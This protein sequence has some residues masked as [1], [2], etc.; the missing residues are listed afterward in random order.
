MPTILALDTAS[1]VCSIAL[2]SADGY[3]REQTQTVAREHTQRILPMINEMLAEADIRLQQVDAIAFSCGPGSFTGL[4]ICLSIAQGLAYGADLPLVPVSSLLAMAAGAR[5]TLSLPEQSVII[6]V[7]DARMDEVYWAAYRVNAGLQLEAI[8]DESVGTPDQCYHRILQLAYDRAC[9][10]GSGW[11][12]PI[13]QT[14]INIDIEPNFYGTAYDIAELGGAFYQR[15]Q[16]INPM[17][18][19]PTYLRNEISWQKRQRI[20]D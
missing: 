15:G 9:A 14:A 12:S 7:L 4:R 17:D 18:A 2:L 13:L 6:S 11:Q 16:C 19:Q 3:I 10:V 1:D 20:R 5:R 8:A